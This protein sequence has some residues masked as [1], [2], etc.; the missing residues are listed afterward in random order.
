M[1]ESEKENEVWRILEEVINENIRE[2]EAIKTMGGTFSGIGIKYAK[3]EN[4]SLYRAE[5]TLSMSTA[6]AVHES[7]LRAMVKDLIQSLRAQDGL[8]L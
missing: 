3:I 1:N 2:N 8:V 4:H 5:C 7:T 6:K